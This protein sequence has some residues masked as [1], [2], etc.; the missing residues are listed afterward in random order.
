MQ[1]ML[2]AIAAHRAP[3][4]RP[5]RLALGLGV[6]GAS[7]IA[8]IAWPERPQPAPY[9]LQPLPHRDGLQHAAISPDGSRFAFVQ[10]DTLVI[11]YEHDNADRVL[12]EH[13][14]SD[15]PISWSPDGAYL[16]VGTES[17]NALWVESVLVDLSSGKVRL[18]LDGYQPLSTLDTAASTLLGEPSAELRE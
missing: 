11:H 7:A 2:D 1:V 18:K 14:I 4:R 5:W 12:I 10:N 3:R 15:S 13:G 17:D 9:H 8:A 6:L 16:L